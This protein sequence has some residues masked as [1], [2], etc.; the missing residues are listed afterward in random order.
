MVAMIA[1]DERDSLR[2]PVDT[3]F[4]RLL[5]MELVRAWHFI[6]FCHAELLAVDDGFCDSVAAHEGPCDGIDA[7]CQPKASVGV[8]HP[9][10]PPAH[11]ECRRQGEA[12]TPLLKPSFPVDDHS[13]RRD[14]DTRRPFGRARGPGSDVDWR[15]PSPVLA[16]LVQLSC[17]RGSRSMWLVGARPVTFGSAIPTA[18]LRSSTRM[19]SIEGQDVRGAMITLRRLWIH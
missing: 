1:V 8:P 13:R 6:F 18:E 16:K 17:D 19:S 9:R 4:R 2:H 10:K 3:R 12:I 5:E 7:S 11:S 14:E 15:D